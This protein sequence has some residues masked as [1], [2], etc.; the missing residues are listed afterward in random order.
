M[1][2]QGSEES[3]EEES[4]GQD[5]DWTPD[6]SG[7]SGVGGGGRREGPARSRGENQ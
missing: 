4:N 6:D 5:A 1:S 7:L 3:S 2:S